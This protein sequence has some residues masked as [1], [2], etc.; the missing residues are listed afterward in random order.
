MHIFVESATEAA[1]LR[2][3]E[4]GKGQSNFQLELRDVAPVHRQ[5]ARIKYEF[6][7]FE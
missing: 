3:G 1:D 2:L 6:R 7:S 5:L 4:G